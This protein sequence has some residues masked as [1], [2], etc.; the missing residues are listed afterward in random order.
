MSESKKKCRQYNAEYLK[1][2]FVAS[3]GNMQAPMCL[4]CERKFSNASMR[5][6]KMVKH[7]YSMHPDKASKNLA[8]FQS[9]HE[10]FLRRPTLERSFPSTSRTQEHDGLLYSYSDK[11]QLFQPGGCQNPESR[12]PYRSK[13]RQSKSRKV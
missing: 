10:R 9:L 2:G 8:Y 12:N 3:P 1:Y 7:L 4:L 13:S 11:S 5:P 6:C